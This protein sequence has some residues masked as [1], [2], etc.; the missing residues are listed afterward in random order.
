[1]C[2]DDATTQLELRPVCLATGYFHQGVY[3]EGYSALDNAIL[4][5]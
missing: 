5:C 3:M 4:L 2:F 1:M